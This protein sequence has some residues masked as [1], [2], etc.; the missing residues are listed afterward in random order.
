MVLI[1][2]IV[3]PWKGSTMETPK[4][5]SFKD[6]ADYVSVSRSTIY[7]WTHHYDLRYIKINGISRISKDD[8]DRFM[9]RD[10][11]KM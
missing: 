5:L 7:R 2:D 6:A 3:N 1:V 4:Y 8:L 10:E 11:F 9:D